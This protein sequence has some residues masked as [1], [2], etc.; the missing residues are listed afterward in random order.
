MGGPSHGGT[1]Q[2]EVLAERS[3]ESI[4]DD[5]LARV[6][7]V[8]EEFA[9]PNADRND[10]EARFPEESVRA[11]GDEGLFGLVVPRE[12]G[13]LGKGPDGFSKAV[14]HLAEADASLGMIYVMHVC[15]SLCLLQSPATP[16]V[17]E[18]LSRVVEGRH[19]TTLAFSERGSR[20]HFWAPVS[21]ARPNGGT[22]VIN[23]SKS[24]VTSA[25]H[26]ASYVVSTQSP[27]AKDPTESTLYLVDADRPGVRV[28]APWQGIGL[29]GN[30]SSPVVLENVEVPDERRLSEEGRGL[31]TMLETVLPWFNLGVSALSLGIC[32]AAVAGTVRHLTHS[33]L[34]H[35]NQSVG[36]A[37]PVVRARL[38]RMKVRTDSLEGMVDRLVRHLG[39]RSE[40]TLPAVLATKAEANETAIEVTDL[41]MRA[42]GGAAFSGHTTI[43]RNFR[44]ARAG[45][46]MSP[47]VDQLYDFLGRALLGLPLMG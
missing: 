40:A 11:L 2:P 14:A 29:R 37:F 16:A 7:R 19:L 12:Q 47:T 39:A 1:T 20:S 15:G 38:A 41:A 42:C 44:D 28:L 31:G 21:R 5:T 24:W 22:T 33:R 32:R 43:D 36:E 10:R 27:R 26:A 18:T 3:T 23:A 17:T 9:R 34:E 25:G 46:V 45:A 13:G 35:L 6:D 30:A 4:A 8:T